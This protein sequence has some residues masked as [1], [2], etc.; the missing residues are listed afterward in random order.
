MKRTPLTKE[1]IAA[2]SK[3]AR[4]EL[5]KERVEPLAETLDGVFQM[6]DSLD[7]V[8]LGETAPAFAYRAKWEGK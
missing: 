1:D 3:A 4:L 5:P 2:L 8:E 6:L 7:D